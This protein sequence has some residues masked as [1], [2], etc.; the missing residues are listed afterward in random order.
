MSHTFSIILYL[1]LSN[2]FPS[3]HVQG[4]PLLGLL[5]KLRSHVRYSGSYAH[6]YGILIRDPIAFTITVWLGRLSD[7]T[8]VPIPLIVV[9]LKPAPAPL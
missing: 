1:S 9:A 8:Y 7:A 2:C 3:P 6:S 4:F 5:R